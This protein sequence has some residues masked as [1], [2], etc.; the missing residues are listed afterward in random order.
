MQMLTF[1][2]NDLECFYY[3]ACTNFLPLL[4]YYTDVAEEIHNVVFH[5]KRDHL[6]LKSAVR[7]KLK[8]CTYV[9]LYAEKIKRWGDLLGL[10]LSALKVG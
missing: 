10:G 8:F 4:H 6:P 5:L 2:R 1:I 7:A 3:L 9:H